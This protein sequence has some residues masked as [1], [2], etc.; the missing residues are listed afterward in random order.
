MPAPSFADAALGVGSKIGR[1]FSVVSVV[2]TA[3]F[4]FYMFALLSSGAWGGAPSLQDVSDAVQDISLGQASV[5]LLVTLAVALFLHPL[6]FAFVQLLEG[7]WGRSRIARTLAARRILQ[8]RR[9]FEALAVRHHAAREPLDVIPLHEQN[10]EDQKHLVPGLVDADAFYAAMQGFPPEQRR[11]LPTRLGNMLRA[12]E[13]RAGAQYGLQAPLIHP[14]LVLHAPKEHVAFIADARELLDLSVRVCTLAVVAGVLTFVVLFPHGAWL[15]ATL[16]PYA[17]AYVAYRGAVVAANQ[18]GRSVATVIDLDRFELYE[19][20]RIPLP[21]TLAQERERN[22]D[23]MELL[24][25][26]WI[27]GGFDYQHPEPAPQVTIASAFPSV[28][29]ATTA[30]TAEARLEAPPN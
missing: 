10:A 23:L 25:G 2:P 21:K 26:E 9:Q 4:V 17:V 8:V 28:P 29:G 12:H 13:D 24:G 16:G 11:L 30:G 18:Y 15:L 19:Q 6:Q 22:E 20:L 7:Y 1:Y 27:D 14:H 5:L 3:L